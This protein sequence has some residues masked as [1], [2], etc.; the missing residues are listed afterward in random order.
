MGRYIDPDTGVT[1]IIRY[2]SIDDLGNVLQPKLVEGQVQ[3]S[4][5]WKQRLLQDPTLL[6]EAYLACAQAQHAHA[7]VPA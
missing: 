3:L 5:E 4:D 7:L 2:T 6:M 1:E